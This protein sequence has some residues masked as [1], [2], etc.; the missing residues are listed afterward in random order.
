MGPRLIVMPES[1]APDLQAGSL[2]KCLTRRTTLLTTRFIV[3]IRIP[4]ILAHKDTGDA[5]TSTAVAEMGSTGAG[6]TKLDEETNSWTM[7]A[8]S[9]GPHGKTKAKGFMKTIDDDTMEWCWTEYA[10]GGLV[11]TMEMC[12]TSKRQ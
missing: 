3:P 5:G 8:A 6:T 1:F 4:G 2:G 11:K 7:R 9:H 10:M 12:G